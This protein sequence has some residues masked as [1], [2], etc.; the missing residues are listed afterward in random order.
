ML[1]L[2]TLSSNPYL[3]TCYTWA[4]LL[5]HALVSLA[6]AVS[7]AAEGE[8]RGSG[9]ST[10][11]VVGDSGRRAGAGAGAAEGTGE[12]AE[13]A[14]LPPEEARLRQRKLLRVGAK[15]TVHQV[16][17]KLQ[18]VCSCP[19][20]GWEQAVVLCEVVNFGHTEQSC[21]GTCFECNVRFAFTLRAFQALEPKLCAYATWMM[22]LGVAEE[23]GWEA[24]SRL[25]AAAG[26][27]ELPVAQNQGKSFLEPQKVTGRAVPGGADNRSHLWCC[28]SSAGLSPHF[29]AQGSVYRA[30]SVTVRCALTTTPSYTSALHCALHPASPLPQA[31]CRT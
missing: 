2:H 11:A 26:V 29:G 22:H 17:S 25:V 20:Q 21:A 12:E 30:L 15:W 10:V 6:V 19:A 27:G 9:G 18:W 7:A 3:F 14:P 23:A 13:S 16:A 1:L 31:P 8:G 28:S 5:T 24:L 4:G